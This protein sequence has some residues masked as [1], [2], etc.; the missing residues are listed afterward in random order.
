MSF[1]IWSQGGV[2]VLIKNIKSQDNAAMATIIRQNLESYQLDKPGTAYFDPQLDDLM[3]YY[4]NRKDAAYW[5]YELDGQIIGG[6]GYE[7]FDAQRKIA[8][9]QKLYVHPN[10]Q[11]RGIASHLMTHLIENAAEKGIHALYLE[12]ASIL[13][14]ATKLYLHLGF[15]LLDAPIENGA[16]HTAMD[17]WMLKKLQTL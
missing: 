8:E 2:E 4:S 17:I 6:V 16:E 15:E 13:E 10:Y 9:V 11:R 12:T 7:I 3:N 5:I 1:V 14:P